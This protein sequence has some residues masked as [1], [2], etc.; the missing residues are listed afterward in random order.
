MRERNGQRGG[1]RR[2]ERME[3]LVEGRRVGIIREGKEEVRLD[4]G[5][6]Y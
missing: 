1:E 2:E 6:L 4:T 5:L 3:E